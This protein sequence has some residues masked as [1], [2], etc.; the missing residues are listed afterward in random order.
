[1]SQTMTPLRKDTPANDIIKQLYENLWSLD[2]KLIVTV[3]AQLSL[4]VHPT[5]WEG[6]SSEVQLRLVRDTLDQLAETIVSC[7]V[8]GWAMAMA[9]ANG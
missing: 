8:C 2:A 7:A 9:M 4:V 1:M 6:S 3:N 5:V